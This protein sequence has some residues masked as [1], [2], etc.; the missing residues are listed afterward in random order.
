MG[1]FE[2]QAQ[3]AL[4]LLERNT[5]SHTKNHQFCCLVQFY[6]P[7]KHPLLLAITLSSLSLKPGTGSCNCL[8]T[9]HL[10]HGR[11]RIDH[12]H[13]DE[14]LVS[15]RATVYSTREEG[16][17]GIRQRALELEFLVEVAP[18]ISMNFHFLWAS[19]CPS[20]LDNA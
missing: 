10:T 4:P 1:T 2:I 6:L 9:T 7:F 3:S 12:F 17:M 18:S 13:H 5:S 15:P 11:Y 19:V 16:S 14:N 8:L 20:F